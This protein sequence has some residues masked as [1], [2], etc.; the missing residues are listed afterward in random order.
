MIPVPIIRAY[1]PGTRISP[2]R[3]SIIAEL[4]LRNRRPT[5]YGQLLHDFGR[6]VG[7]HQTATIPLPSDQKSQ[8]RHH[9]KICESPFSVTAME[10]SA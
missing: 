8:Q 2:L 6:P 3:A 9:K 7:W 4:R 10:Y 5:V 1:L